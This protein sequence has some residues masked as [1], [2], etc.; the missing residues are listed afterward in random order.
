MSQALLAPLDAILKAQLHAARSFLNFLIQ[1]G[2]PHQPVVDGDGAADAA[3]ASSPTSPAPG[4][5]LAPAGASP[6]GGAPPAGAALQRRAAAGGGGDD[7]VPYRMDFFHEMGGKRQRI[8]IPTLALVPVAPL[9]V[10]DAQFRFDFYVRQIARHPQIQ[11][12]ESEGTQAESV[13]SK[14]GPERKVDRFTRPW[15]LVDTPVSVQGTFAPSSTTRKDDTYERSDEARL[16]VEVKVAA[17]PMPAALEKL[18][19]SLGEVT[20][21]EESPPK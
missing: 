21:V 13:A 10:S 12:S 4:G 6:A 1:L 7:N 16:H 3:S 18:L 5:A 8:S 19:A 2:Y 9:G 11:M 14:D 20:V 17:M 15:F